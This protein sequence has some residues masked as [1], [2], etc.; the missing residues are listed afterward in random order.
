MKFEL[1]DYHRNTSDEELISDVIKTAECLG[2][3]TLTRDEYSL[4]GTYHPDTLTRRFGGWKKVLEL[5][6]LETKGHNFKVNFTDKDVIDDVKR[7]AFIYNQETITVQ[8]YSAYGRF[9]SSTLTR[10]YGGWNKILQ[11][12]GM[13]LN[14]NR[15]FTTDEMLEEIER[16]WMLLGRQPTTTDIK[17]GISKFSLQSYARR[18]GGWRGALKAFVAYIDDDLVEDSADKPNEENLKQT[19]ENIIVLNGHSTT[20][21][22]NLRLR[23]LVMKRDNFK[24]CA[25]GASPAKDQSVELHI[26]HII[27]WSKGGETT[28]DNLQTLCSKCNLGKSDLL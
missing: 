6:N 23:F 3:S 15:N 4:N 12:A 14:Q 11:L 17:N 8:E 9:H 20:R 19:K 27:P 22:I 18:F 16:L 10:H 28:I 24:C 7:V 13:S 1:N 21:D 5:S 26:D 25:C 2:K